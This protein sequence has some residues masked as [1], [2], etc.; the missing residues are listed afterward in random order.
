MKRVLVAGIGNIFMG[1]D[2]F[3]CEVVQQ[4]ARAGMPAEVDLVD[5][6]I[7]GLDLGY[8]LTDGYELVILID[9]I[10]QN[11]AP[12]TVFVIEPEF[13]NLPT[14]AGD[15]DDPLIPMHEMDPAKVLRLVASLGKRRPRVLLVACQPESLGG[16]EGRMG[17]SASVQAA[18]GQAMSDVRAIVDEAMGASGNEAGETRVSAQP[19]AWNNN[20]ALPLQEA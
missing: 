16:E 4:L 15:A 13:E 2:A 9:A 3:G 14:D 17:L 19:T 10:D 7:R 5:F 12:G 18:I 8:A 1:D 11:E 6:G 20:E